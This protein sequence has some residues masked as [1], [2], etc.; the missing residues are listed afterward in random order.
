MKIQNYIS[1]KELNTLGL[2]YK[3]DK[4]IHISSGEDARQLLESGSLIN[5]PVLIL[6]EGS[7]LLFTS[8]FHGTIIHSSIEGITIEEEKTDYVIISAGAGIN[9]DKFVEWCVKKGYGGIENLSYIPGTVGATPVQNIG[10]YGVEVKD[11]I[12]KVQAIS[13]SDGKQKEFTNEECRFRYRDSIFKNELKNKYLIT[14]VFYRLPLNAP[15]VI[16][17]GNL[18]DEIEKTGSLS[19]KNIRGAVINIRRSKLP[20]PAETGN[21][22]SFFRNPLISPDEAQ[23]LIEKYPPI[24]TFP[25]PSGSI[26]IAAAWLIEQC[27]WKGKRTGDAGVHERHALVL[28]NYGKATGKEIFDLSEKIRESVYQKFGIFL[29]REVEVI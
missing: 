8:D 10:A 17:Y 12:F 13:L 24:P 11:V 9:W 21:A 1:L 6:G 4:F 16:S 7:N 14:R 27:G 3:A 26:K 20:D 19:L 25:D 22:G 28:V 18:K 23:Y 15:F 2:D 5:E 29:E